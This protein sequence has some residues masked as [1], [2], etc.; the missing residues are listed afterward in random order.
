MSKGL[1]GTTYVGLEELWLGIQV[2]S[3]AYILLSVSIPSYRNLK[4]ELESVRRGAVKDKQSFDEEC[5]QLTAKIKGLQKSLKTE[6][7]ERV[8]LKEELN[9]KQA[10]LDQQEHV[11]IDQICS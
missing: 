3:P 11:S 1:W 2:F 10:Q 7:V 4:G 8:T 5:F 6:Q 9:K